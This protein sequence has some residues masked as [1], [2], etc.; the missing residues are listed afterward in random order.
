MVVEGRRAGADKRISRTN[1]NCNRFIAE[2]IYLRGFLNLGQR[3]YQKVSV[4]D[5]EDAKRIAKRSTAKYERA[6]KITRRDYEVGLLEMDI[7]KADAALAEKKDKPEIAGLPGLR[8]PKTKNSNSAWPNIVMGIVSFI[9]G[10]ALMIFWS[11]RYLDSRR[12]IIIIVLS[13]VLLAMGFIYF[14][15]GLVGK[16]DT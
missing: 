11:S 15:I 3:V 10:I 13:G 5:F 7:E 9:C 6:E 12:S 1:A 14:V 8:T 4:N 16:R 2:M